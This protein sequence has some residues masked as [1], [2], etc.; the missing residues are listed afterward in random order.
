MKYG[1]RYTRKGHGGYPSEQIICFAAR[2]YYEEDR[3]QVKILDFGCGGGSHTWY[4]VR[5]G[6]DAYTDIPDGLLHNRGTS[7]F[8]EKSDLEL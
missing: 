1:M 3:K 5:E 4:L 8:N 6:F 2:N 7:H